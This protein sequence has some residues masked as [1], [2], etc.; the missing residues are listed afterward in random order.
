[1]DADPCSRLHDAVALA[2]I[3]LYTDVLAAVSDADAPLTPEELDRV[4]GLL[5]P[6]PANPPRLRVSCTRSAR[7]GTSE[8][9]I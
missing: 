4:L 9:S 7:R 8:L 2:E 6:E 5:P 3:D 1:M